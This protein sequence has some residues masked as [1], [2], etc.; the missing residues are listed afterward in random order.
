[1]TQMNLSIKQIQTHRQEQTYGCQGGEVGRGMEW[2]VAVS[3]CKLL[4][5]EVINNKVLLHSTE[6]YI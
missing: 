2:E 1:M 6:H 5:T 3:R 4:Y